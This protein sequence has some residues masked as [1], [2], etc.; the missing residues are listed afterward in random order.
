MLSFGEATIEKKEK[1]IKRKPEIIARNWRKVGVIKFDRLNISLFIFV[2]FLL[3]KIISYKLVP[4]AFSF[5]L[6]LFKPRGIGKIP[7]LWLDSVWTWVFCSSHSSRSFHP[8]TCRTEQRKSGTSNGSKCTMAFP[9]T[10]TRSGITANSVMKPGVVE[11]KPVLWNVSA[12][13]SELSSLFHSRYHSRPYEVSIGTYINAT[14]ANHVNWWQVP[15]VRRGMC[16]TDLQCLLGSWSLAVR[17][18]SLC[19]HWKPSA[20]VVTHLHLTPPHCADQV[21]TGLGWN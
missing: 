14:P 17:S 18:L 4:L 1:I 2:C 13:P 8:N 20:G 5:D 7:L 21:F 10:R 19:Q 3:N 12:P 6:R 11:G 16:L 9:T 15:P